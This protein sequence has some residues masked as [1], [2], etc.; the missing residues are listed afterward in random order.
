LPSQKLSSQSWLAVAHLAPED[1]NGYR[2]LFNN[3]AELRLLWEFL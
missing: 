1:G 3:G 2:R